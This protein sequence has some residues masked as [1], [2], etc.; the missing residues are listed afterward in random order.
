MYSKER[1]V[2]IALEKEIQKY[3][4]EI[5]MAIEYVNHEKNDKK[6]VEERLEELLEKVK[7]V[8][9]IH[10][11][12]YVEKTKVRNQYQALKYKVALYLDGIVSLK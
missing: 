7:L 11:R 1:D 2:L 5:E 4:D 12:K 3:E 8:M 10:E 6:E 9:K